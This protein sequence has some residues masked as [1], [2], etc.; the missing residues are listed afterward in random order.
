M[1]DNNYEIVYEE[2]GEV[3]PP[4]CGEW[5]RGYLDSPV[6][7]RSDFV[8]QSFP[9]LRMRLVQDDEVRP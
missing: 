1:S 4:R 7:A 8:I 5:F 2:T 9:I 3:R 6:R